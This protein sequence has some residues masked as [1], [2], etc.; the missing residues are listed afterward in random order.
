MLSFGIY[1]YYYWEIPRKTLLYM[2]REI[3]KHPQPFKD[4]GGILLVSNTRGMRKTLRTFK[5]H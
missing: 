2:E 5:V 4:M 3:R 1:Q